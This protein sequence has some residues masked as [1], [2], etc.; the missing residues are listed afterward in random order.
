MDRRLFLKQSAVTA[1]ALKL[2]LGR[3]YSRPGDGLPD[4]AVP[5]ITNQ[6]LSLVN[7]ERT[8]AGLRSLKLDALACRVAQAHAVEMARNHY[9]SHWGLD[10][11]KPYHRYSFA[12]GFEAIQEN[13]SAFNSTTPIASDE[14]PIHLSQ[15]H[16]SMH[17]E[18]PPNDGHRQTILNPRHTHVGFGY[19]DYGF[20]V[21]LCE[22]YISR[23][24]S[25]DP[26]AATAAPQSKFILGGQPLERVHAVQS[27]DVHYEPLPS[28]PDMA[29]LRVARPYG[30]PEERESLF[31]KLRENVVYEDGSKGSIEIRGDGKFRAPIVLSRK[32]PGIYTIV[33]WLQ[34][35][36]TTDAFPAT[37]VCVRAE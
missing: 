30:L 26:Y 20:A 6:L 16:R 7:F 37:Q 35:S 28:P 9:L 4:A 34:K 18:S 10:G 14:V 25:I 5:A 19:A 12:G 23:Y 17:D 13:G 2:G 21:R 31:P 29:W 33:V 22:I 27:I 32:E 8:D 36:G 1:V 11:R 15:M 3:A 24:I